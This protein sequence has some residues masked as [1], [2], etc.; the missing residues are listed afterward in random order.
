MVKNSFSLSSKCSDMKSEVAAVLDALANGRNLTL[1]SSN[2]LKRAN[3]IHSVFS[4]LREQEEGAITYYIE[5]SK[6]RTQDEFSNLFSETILGK[7]KVSLSVTFHQLSALEKRVYIAIDNFQQMIQYPKKGFD[8]LLRSY[9]QELNN[10]TFI[11]AG[12]DEPMMH[13][14]FISPAKPFY[15]STQILTQT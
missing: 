5:I 8:A 10:V 1:V 3:L 7:S 9:V 4:Y 2:C 13:E 11:F 14:M 12:N 15:Q 6:T